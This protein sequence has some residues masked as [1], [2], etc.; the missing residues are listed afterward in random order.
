MLRAELLSW[1]GKRFDADAADATLEVAK[2]LGLAIDR[3]DAQNVAGAKPPADVRKTVVGRVA[4]AQGPGEAQDCTA[5]QGPGGA[6][7]C[8]HR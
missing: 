6:Q 1:R 8:S 7:E 5:A 4:A 3:I 2:A